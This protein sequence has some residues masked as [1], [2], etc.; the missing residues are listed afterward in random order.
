[1]QRSGIIPRRMLQVQHQDLLLW[2][3]AFMQRGSSQCLRDGREMTHLRRGSFTC[4]HMAGGPPP[5]TA[6]ERAIGGGIGEVTA[7]AMH[8]CPS[9][10]LLGS[11]G[12]S[13]AKEPTG[14]GEKDR[15]GASLTEEKAPGD[16]ME[17]LGG[18]LKAVTTCCAFTSILSDSC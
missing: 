13:M 5:P 2:Q 9:P 10:P 3:K 15:E 1:M 11:L 18:V 6:R 8:G 17:G 16:G 14:S 7:C 12:K 4:A